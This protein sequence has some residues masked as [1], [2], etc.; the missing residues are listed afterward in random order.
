MTMQRYEEGDSRIGLGQT[1]LDAGDLI[2]P[3]I[4]VVQKMSQEVDDKRAEEGDLFNTLTGE[5]MDRPLR[6]MPIVPFKQRVFLLRDERRPRADAELAAAHL[7]EVSEGSGLKCRS[8]DMHQGIGDPGVLCETECPLS[9][10]TA[11]NAPPLCSETYNVAA[12]TELGELIVLSFA[13]SSAKTGK[14][15]FSMIRMKSGVPWATIYSMDTRTERNDQGSFAVPEVTVTKDAPSTELLTQA[16]NWAKQLQGAIID[17][18][19]DE[20]GEEAASPF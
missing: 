17:V 5:V 20:A 1:H 15:V 16:V 19:P 11:D 8:Y 13:K 14:K 2:L 6:F 7:G 12:M 4:K 10:W 9:K 18:T 3:R